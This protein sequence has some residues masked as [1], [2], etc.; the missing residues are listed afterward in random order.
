MRPV[1]P[2]FSELKME[3][4][5]VHDC[6]AN[7]ELAQAPTCIARL[8]HPS[9]LPVMA[10]SLETAQELDLLHKIDCTQIQDF[11]IFHAMSSDQ[12][13]QLLS[14]DGPANAYGLASGC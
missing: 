2:S 5:Q 1:S 14:H 10:G 12:F 11:L 6:N 4:I 9:G 7:E 3:R 13:R 8:G